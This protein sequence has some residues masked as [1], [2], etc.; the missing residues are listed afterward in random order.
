MLIKKCNII[1]QSVKTEKKTLFFRENA[2]FEKH[3]CQY[4]VAMV[5]VD[6]HF[7]TTL[8]CFQ[9]NFRKSRHFRWAWTVSKFYNFL[10]RGGGGEGGGPGVLKA[11]LVWVGFCCFVNKVIST[12]VREF[13]FLYT[14]I[15]PLKNTTN[16]F[17]I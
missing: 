14:F 6:A 11:S 4:L 15:A 1:I 16:Y 8:Q 2:N 13:H 5:N 12:Q 3:G 9:I 17:L 7:M 10:A